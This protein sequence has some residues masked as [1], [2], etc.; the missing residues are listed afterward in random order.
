M[1]D[2]HCVIYTLINPNVYNGFFKTLSELLSCLYVF[3]KNLSF[4]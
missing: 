3:W 1:I 4:V 2:R